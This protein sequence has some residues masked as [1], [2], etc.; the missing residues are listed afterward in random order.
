MTPGEAV[1]RPGGAELIREDAATPARRPLHGPPKSLN[2][3]T[4][5]GLMAQIAMDRVDR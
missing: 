4:F 5:E 2:I 1:H 3:I